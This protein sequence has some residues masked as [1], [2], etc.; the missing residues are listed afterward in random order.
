[1]NI[2]I[3]HEKD[4]WWIAEATDL[5]GIMAYGQSK[6]RHFIKSRSCRCE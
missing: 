4:G 6:K 5:P 2:E 1:M 3:E